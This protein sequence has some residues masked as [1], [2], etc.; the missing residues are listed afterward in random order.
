VVNIAYGKI[1]NSETHMLAKTVGTMRLPSMKKLFAL[2]L[3]KP[4]T[5][6]IKE[7]S[8][9][10]AATYHLRLATRSDIPSIMQCNLQNLPENY[11]DYFYENHL[12]NYPELCWV[13]ETQ[14]DQQLVGYALGRVEK[15]RHSFG[16]RPTASGHP[17]GTM[18]GHVVSLAVHKPY[19]GAKVGYETTFKCL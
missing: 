13:C 12:T 18:L 6:C 11:N 15:E 8:K 3:L 7:Y 1:K 16:G 2:Y 17:P 4:I 9:A 10:S 14:E 5:S 19:R